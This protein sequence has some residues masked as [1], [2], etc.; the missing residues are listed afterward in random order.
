ML[1]PHT[2]GFIEK[3]KNNNNKVWFEENRHLF[4]EAKSDFERLVKDVIAAFGKVDT[5]IAPLQAKDCIFRQYRDIRFSPDKTPYKVHMGAS[6]D[7]GGKKSGFAG[8]YLHIEPGNKSM[9]GG[10]MWM[11]EGEQI[12]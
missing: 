3:L 8:Y 7:R 10:G 11:P 4:D 6:F 9:V 2:P 5:D 1:K 12:K